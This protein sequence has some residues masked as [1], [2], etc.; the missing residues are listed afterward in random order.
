MQTRREFGKLTAASL[1]AFSFNRAFSAPPKLASTIRS[2]KVGVESYG[3]IPY[4]QETVIDLVIQTMQQMGLRSCSLQEFLLVPPALRKVIDDAGGPDRSAP[5]SPQALAKAKDADAQWAH[6]RATF[7]LDSLQAVRKKFDAGGI[8]L[9]AYMPNNLRTPETSSDELLIRNCEIAKAL[10]VN[11]LTVMFGKD[12]AKRFVPIA[13]KYNMRVGLHGRSTLKPANSDQIG[14]PEDYV[15][16]CGL[17]QNYGIHLDIGNAVA[18]GID[19]P[20]FLEKHHQHFFSLA[21]K[22]RSKDRKSHPWGEG[23]S[24]VKEILQLVQREHYPITCWIDC[25]IPVTP[26]RTRIEDIQ[27]CF[28]FAK[29]ALEE[30]QRG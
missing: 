12:A 28:I 22:D 20:L 6:W 3:F 27:Q 29:R 16:A 13:E 19:V 1:G 23:D 21:I 25:D 7:P 24:R 17:S 8:E 18:G 14:T 15:E 30:E 4:P 5:Q 11:Y 10:Q 2:V 26:Q 9:T